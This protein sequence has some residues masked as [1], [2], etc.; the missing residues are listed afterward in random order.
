MTPTNQALSLYFDLPF[1]SLA[2]P[3]LLMICALPVLPAKSTPCKCALP[4]VPR[5]V[6]TFAIASVMISQFLG[7]MGTLTSSGYSDVA[8]RTFG[9]SSPGNATCGRCM[10]PPLV[11]PPMAR[12]N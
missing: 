8:G 9:G 1:A 7:S 3:V 4:A 2:F 11:I 5:G 10:T 12:A 6:G